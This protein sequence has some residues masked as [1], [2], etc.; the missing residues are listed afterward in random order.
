M[1]DKKHQGLP[2][3]GYQAQLPVAVEKV[4]RNKVIEEQMLRLLDELAVAPK[5]DQRWLA[6][7]RTEIERGFM[8]VNRAVFKPARVRLDG[9]S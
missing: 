3:A 8:A 6:M 1:T 5:I 9:D 4:N 2:V 7:G